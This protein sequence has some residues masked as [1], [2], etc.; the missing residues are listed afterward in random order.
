[1]LP[2]VTWGAKSIIDSRVVSVKNFAYTKNEKHSDA[3]KSITSLYILYK[4]LLPFN[5][6][7]YSDLPSFLFLVMHSPFIELNNIT[8]LYIVL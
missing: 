4:D 7:K 1:M 6:I 3:D 8:K 2:F 5:C